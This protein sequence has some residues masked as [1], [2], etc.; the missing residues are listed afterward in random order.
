[1]SIKGGAQFGASNSLSFQIKDLFRR[2]C[3]CSQFCPQNMWETL[4]DDAA[5]RTRSWL[6]AFFIGTK[7]LM[8]INDLAL[9]YAHCAQFYP[10]K[11]FAS[12]VT[13]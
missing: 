12:R 4:A 5:P 1:M 11:M 6:A 8:I 13:G 9:A 10:Q 7:I 3:H 2:G